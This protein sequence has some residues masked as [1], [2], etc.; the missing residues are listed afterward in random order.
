M[1][2]FV[3]V[4][5]FDPPTLGHVALVEA[6][7]AMGERVVVFVAYNAAKHPLFDA[8]SRCELMRASLSHLDGVDVE[9]VTGL[10]AARARDLGAHALVKGV[11]DATDVSYEIAQA[12]I[13]R[14]IAHIETILLP[15][16]PHL[17]AVSS[18]LVKELARLGAD[19]SP[20]VPDP[21]ARALA[22]CCQGEQS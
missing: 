11:R 7:R 6:A 22:D 14:D 12:D 1:A 8:R 4:G 13:N 18:S 9:I 5:T 16:P 21:V 10:V 19:V 3:V 20:Y 17:R 15:A 2:L